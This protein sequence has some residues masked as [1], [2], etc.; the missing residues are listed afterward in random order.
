M[1]ELPSFVGCIV[2][3]SDRLAVRVKLRVGFAWPHE[4]AVVKVVQ[5]DG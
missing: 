3:P 2:T 1:F 4:A 5:L